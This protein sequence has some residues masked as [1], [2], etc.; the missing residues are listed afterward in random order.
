[1]DLMRP[2]RQVTAINIRG[3]PIQLTIIGAIVRQVQPVRWINRLPTR[4]WQRQHAAACATGP[5]I[6]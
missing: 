2:V 6:A 3:D 1:M 5:P 4:R